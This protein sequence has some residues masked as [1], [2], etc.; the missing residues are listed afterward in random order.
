[1]LYR[2]VIVAPKSKVWREVQKE[3]E[4]VYKQ[5][6]NDLKDFEEN[7]NQNK[8]KFYEFE[9]FK[10]SEISH[11]ANCFVKLKI[12]QNFNNIEKN[13]GHSDEF[14]ENVNSYKITDDELNFMKNNLLLSDNT[15]ESKEEILIRLF[16]NEESH[17]AVYKYWGREHL[18]KIIGTL[19]YDK[20]LYWSDV[21]FLIHW[22][23]MENS[24]ISIIKEA[25]IKKIVKLMLELV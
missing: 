13:I 17:M 1:M 8:V 24:F 6:V 14:L 4:T 7:L 11:A 21:T 23:Q 12:T 16:T 5:C 19:T 15:S 18:K 22:K 10:E 9:N 2:E 20:C 3:D 25:L